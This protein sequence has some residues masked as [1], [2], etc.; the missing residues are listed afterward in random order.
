MKEIL[1]KLI[2]IYQKTLSRDHGWLSAFYPT[3]YCRYQPTCSEYA[4]Q[5]IKE[6]GVSKGIFLAISRISRCHPWGSIGSDPILNRE[7]N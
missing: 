6:H 5:S 1:I 3:G 4:K 7:T 2:T